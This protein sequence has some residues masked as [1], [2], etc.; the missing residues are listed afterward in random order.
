MALTHLDKKI[1]GK[2]LSDMWKRELCTGRDPANGKWYENGANNDKAGLYGALTDNA[3]TELL[4]DESQKAYTPESIVCDTATLD[5]RNGLA[6]QST[7]ELAYTYANATT[8]T[9]STTNSIKVGVGFEIKA[10]ASI[11]GIG[12]EATSKINF[13]YTHSW[14]DSRS[15][16]VSQ[17][18]TFKQSVPIN[19]PSGRV[20]QVVLTA[21]SQ[22]LTVPYRALIY[23]DGITETWFEGRVKGHYNWSL[24]AGLAFS[25]IAQWGLAGSES[26]SYG[27]DPK[28][29]YRGVIT[30]H[31]QVTAAQ[32]ADFVAKVYDITDTYKD[33]RAPRLL[34]IAPRESMPIS[35]VLVEEI[36]F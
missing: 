35:G 34:R 6:P 32:T 22:Q 29:P 21:K 23:V 25:K 1:L 12:G 31:G 8:T 5:N 4:F 18:H 24:G 15:E 11:F 10:K 3:S 7:V 19:V 28:Q 20:Y 27:R 33:E 2:Y 9:H 14:T 26:N 17:S 16:N 30:Q 13:E 36:T